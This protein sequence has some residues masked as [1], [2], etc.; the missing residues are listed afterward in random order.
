MNNVNIL[1]FEVVVRG[2]DRSWSSFPFDSVG[3][4]AL[5][6]GN[7]SFPYETTCSRDLCD[8]Y[9]VVLSRLSRGFIGAF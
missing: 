6:G 4:E 3:L 2:K 8:I 9:A 5:E 7:W 1:T